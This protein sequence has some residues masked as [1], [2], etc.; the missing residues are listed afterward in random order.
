MRWRG[1]RET[2]VAAAALASLGT[3]LVPAA[4]GRAEAAAGSGLSVSGKQI[5]LDGQPFQP[6]GFT[7]VAALGATCS[8]VDAVAA[9]S[10][11]GPPEL[12]TLVT[13]WRANTVRLQVSQKALAGPSAASY[14]S[15]TIVPDVAAAEAAGLVVI[16]SMQD[17]GNVVCG[18]GNQLPTQAT[19]DA[20]TNLAPAFVADPRVMLELFN[21]PID[22]TKSPTTLL[23]LPAADWVQ[24]HDGGS[25]DNVGNAEIGMQQLVTYLRSTLSVPNVLLADGLNRSGVLPGP[26]QGGYLLT[27]TLAQ[28]KIA[29]SIHPYYYTAGQADW[30]FRFGSVAASVPVVATE[31][32]YLLTECGTAAQTMAPSF[33][34]YLAA[35]GIGVLG[36]SADYQAAATRSLMADWNMTPTTCG[37]PQSGPGVD[38][39]NYAITPPSPPGGQLHPLVSARILDTRTGAPSG[40]GQLLPG[41]Q[42]FVAP[43]GLGGVPSTDVGAVLLDITA[44]DTSGSGSLTVYPSG[45]ARPVTVN[46]D[47]TKGQ[48]VTD[49][50]AVQL[51]QAGQVVIYNAGSKANVIVDVEGWYSTAATDRG[52]RGL[53]DPVAASRILDTRTHLG[54]TAPGAGGTV[55]LKV[56]G[57]GGVPATGVSAVALELTAMSGTAKTYLTA[58]PSGSPRPL[59]SNLSV[60]AKKTVANR[61]VVPVGPDGKVMLYNAAGVQQLTADVSGWFT[62]GTD[63]AAPGGYFTAVTPS[64]VLDTRSGTGVAKGPLSAGHSLTV[65]V[66][67]LAGVPAAGGPGSATAVVVSLTSTQST[68]ATS[69]IAYPSGTVPLTS[70]L[71]V[72]AG[73]TVANLVVAQLAPDGTFQ[74]YDAA[75][76][77]QVVVDVLGYVS[78]HLVGVAG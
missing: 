36:F 14:I 44:T 74:V 37:T 69:L 42:Q 58:Y 75:G 4:T 43:E 40:V 8:E 7:M 25:L 2:L 70:D 6:R 54:G 48:T 32:N 62:D 53:Y 63:T 15:S 30:D 38:F 45:T 17:Q 16:L 31:W 66:A 59:T 67:G 78:G 77:T 57:V 55:Q 61:V 19:E 13:R 28:P 5:L 50:V 68:L 23:P 51:G 76:R 35:R 3:L 1:R 33:L 47:Y 11:F 24:W 52:A 21:E 12:S 60:P 49:L 65:H 10:H 22:D 26:N 64:R 27:D 41:G 9:A 46:L 29:Y 39:L 20:W 73:R 34:S 56:T 18:D 71:S 72:P